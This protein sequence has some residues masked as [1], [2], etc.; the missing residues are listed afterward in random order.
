[1]VAIKNRNGQLWIDSPTPPI[2]FGLTKTNQIKH[3]YLQITQTHRMI[4]WESLECRKLFIRIIILKTFFKIKLSLK[5]MSQA[6]FFSSLK[7]WISVIVESD[8]TLVVYGRFMFQFKFPT[9]DTQTAFRG[10]IL[11]LLLWLYT[12]EPNSLTL[13]SEAREP[14]GFE[15]FCRRQ[16]LVLENCKWKVFSL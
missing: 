4:Y 1:M 7:C 8:H 14:S 13:G 10:T 9:W 15:D 5:N 3:F 6:L 16:R 11:L 2:Q 12:I